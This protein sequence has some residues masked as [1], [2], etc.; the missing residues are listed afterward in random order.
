MAIKDNPFSNY[1]DSYN[2]NSRVDHPKISVGDHSYYAGYYHGKHFEDCVLYIDNA[3]KNKDVDKLV[4][5][6]YCSIASG[7]LF[8]MG[9]NHGHNYD[10][11]A[12]HPLDGFE[13][14]KSSSKKFPTSFKNKGD[15]IIGHDVWIGFEALIMP[16]IKIGDGSVIASRAVVTKDVEPYSIVGGN[17]AKLIKKRFS[18]KDIRT[19]LKIKW[20][21]WPEDKIRKNLE[22]FRDNN[23]SKLELL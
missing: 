10:A 16:G 15:T 19:L 23:V 12:S 20:W 4:I 2:I 5:G 3:D 8:M 7:A 1:R 13:S 17:P 22:L 6:K 18:D 21:D 11:I 9:G 14:K